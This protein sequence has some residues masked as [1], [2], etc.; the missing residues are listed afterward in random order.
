VNDI[1]IPNEPETQPAAPA[2]E[3]APP[4]HDSTI[5]ESRDGE[6][7]SAAVSPQWG[8]PI[9]IGVL[10]D[11]HVTVPRPLNIEALNEMSPTAAVAL[12]LSNRISNLEQ[13]MGRMG[14]AF[15]PDQPEATPPEE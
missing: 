9:L 1:T 12:S 6:G 11:R 2:T 7:Q 14:Q 15:L 3:P 4:P 5:T 10:G 8:E 13:I